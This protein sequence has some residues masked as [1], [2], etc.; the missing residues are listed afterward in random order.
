MLRLSHMDEGSLLNPVQPVYP[1]LARQARVQ[2][3]VLLQAV[4]S[5]QGTIENLQVLGGPPLL[6]KSALDAVRQW[7][8]R[9]YILNGEAVEVETR[10][11]VNFTLSG[12]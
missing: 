8:Y 9:P 11:T 4:I 2:G 6:V 5:R 10:I 1:A 7:R 12:G 3:A